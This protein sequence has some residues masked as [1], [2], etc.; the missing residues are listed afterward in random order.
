MGSEGKSNCVGHDD[1]KRTNNSMNGRTTQKYL[2]SPEITPN[3]AANNQFALISERL[4]N[5]AFLNDIVL[6]TRTTPEATGDRPLKLDTDRLN[7]IDD[8]LASVILQY[9][10]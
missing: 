6:L 5:P 7:N 8:I 10:I 9:G 1:Y 2:N 4:R 3:N